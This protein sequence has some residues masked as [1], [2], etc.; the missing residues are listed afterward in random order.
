MDDP[1][2]VQWQDTVSWYENQDAYNWGRDTSTSTTWVTPWV[3]ASATQ[4]WSVAARD[5]DGDGDVDVLVASKGDGTVA[6]Y[7]NSGRVGYTP[8][9]DFAQHLIVANSQTAC[10]DKG[11]TTDA[12]GNSCPWYNIHSGDCG[13]YDNAYFMAGSLC[14]GCGGGRAAS[15]FDRGMPFDAAAADLDDD[16][17]IDVVA[18][19]WDDTGVAWY[20]SDCVTSPPTYA[21]FNPVAGADAAADGAVPGGGIHGTGG[22]GRFRE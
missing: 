2:R 22:P 14:C 20:G 5:L 10:E 21:T 16:G 1:G 19:F 3:T 9:V 12:Q 17:A 7:E 8:R 18:A 4:A 6:W 13:S 11:S 15:G